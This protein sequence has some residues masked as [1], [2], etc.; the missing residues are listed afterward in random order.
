MVL[1]ERLYP[2]QLLCSKTEIACQFYRLK[3]EFGRQIFTVNVDMGRLIRFMAV[4]IK[5][6]GAV[7][8]RR[9][10]GPIVLEKF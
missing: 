2:A 7:P 10:H 9:W 4:E 6:K 8:K 1:Y 5:P 3:P